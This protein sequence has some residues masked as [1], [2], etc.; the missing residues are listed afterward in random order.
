MISFLQAKAH[1]SEVQDLQAN[2]TDA[3]DKLADSRLEVTKMKSNLVD[4]KTN[5]EIQLCEMQ[6]KLNEV[7]F[8]V[9]LWNNEL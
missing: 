5:F 1:L 9:F 4:Q 7:R 3:E 2:L 8:I 6:T